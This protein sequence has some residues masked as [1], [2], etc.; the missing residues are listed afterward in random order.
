[1][2]FLIFI[3]G[4]VFNVFIALSGMAREIAT[5]V[6][7]LPLP[8][9]VIL[10]FILS[11]YIPLGCLMD[12]LALLVLTTPIYLPIYNSFGFDLIWVGVLMV[13]L[14]EI[15]LITPPMG[16]NLFVI[17]DVAASSKQISLGE[18]YKG[19]M[20]FIIIDV[21]ALVI[22]VA[23]PRISLFLPSLMH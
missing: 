1:M 23:F 21:V 9:L 5:F 15:G 17:K 11:T 13:I 2:I 18:V 6:G 16:L 3:G 4:T 12:S 8:P 22:L 10:S 20:P 14:I 7:A 19:V